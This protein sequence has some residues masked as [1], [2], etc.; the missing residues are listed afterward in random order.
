MRAQAPAVTNLLPEWVRE[1]SQ[2]TK[3]RRSAQTK[4]PRPSIGPRGEPTDLVKGLIRTA[5]RLACPCCTK[6]RVLIY[7]VCFERE[8]YEEKKK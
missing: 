5:K 4:P 6:P 2:K 8:E 3:A 7:F 1:V